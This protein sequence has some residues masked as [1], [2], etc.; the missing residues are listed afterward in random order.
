MYGFGVKSW[1]EFFPVEIFLK[2]IFEHH[3]ILARKI[4]FNEEYLRKYFF[5]KK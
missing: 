3:Q 2:I 5:W 4:Y 1:V